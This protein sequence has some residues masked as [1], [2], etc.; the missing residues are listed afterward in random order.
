[1][2]RH[3]FDDVACLLI[4]LVCCG[5]SNRPAAIAQVDV[6]PVAVAS[7]LLETCDEDGD[8]AL[9]A[10]ETQRFG[11][12]AK[13]FASYDLNDDDR[14]DREELS[15]RI[16]DVVF[17]PHKRLMSGECV[18]KRKGRPLTNAKVCLK[19][20]DCLSGVIPPAAGVTNPAGFARLQLEEE[21]M[22]AGAP[23]LPGLVRPGLYRVEITHDLIPVPARFNSQSV[24][25]AEVS[26]ASLNEG[27]LLVDLDF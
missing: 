13:Y 20:L 14:L 10:D 21:D 26:S 5:C 8:E 16:G 22:P 19:P 23:R 27:P 6:D 12:L 4:A 25:T 17:N 2:L 7:S 9:S 18:V 3:L 11:C 1:L 24:L 15:G